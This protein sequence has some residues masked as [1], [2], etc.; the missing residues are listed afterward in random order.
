MT[1]ASFS[2]ELPV[3]HDKAQSLPFIHS[4]FS[5]LGRRLVWKL[6]FHDLCKALDPKPVPPIHNAMQ[7]LLARLVRSDGPMTWRAVPAVQPTRAGR[8]GVGAGDLGERG[9]KT[10]GQGWEGAFSL[11]KAE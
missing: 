6:D 8:R 2:L 5:L 3:V 11:W 9:N 10:G 1:T 7:V 4:A